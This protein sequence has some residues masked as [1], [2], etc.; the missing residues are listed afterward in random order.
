L[1]KTCIIIVGPTAVGKTSLAI[2]LA[3]HFNTQII[4]ADSRQ[5]FTALNIGVAKPS[6]QQLNAVPHHF[7]NSHSISD[8]INAAVFEQYALNKINNIFEKNDYAVMVGG[9]GLYV[10][11]FCNGIDELPVINATIRKNIIDEYEQH[12]LS[13]LQNKVQQIDALYFEK[14]EIKNP[15]RLMRALE[16]KLSTGQS[17]LSFQTQQKKNRDFNIL[18]IGLHLPKE[19]L[20][21][22]IN[23]RVD[24]MLEQGLLDEVKSL[25]G[26]KNQNALQTVGYTELFDYLEDKV[27]FNQAVELIKIHTRQYAKRQLTWFKK[28]AAIHWLSPQI[29]LKDLLST[30]A[31]N[32]AV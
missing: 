1:K 13:W 26:F 8:E 17:I 23:D 29:S 31:K 14:G 21:K 18:K 7:I 16:V 2:L 10:N 12:G 15:Q 32:S 27:T 11:S 5:C 24:D 3:Q 19:N 4:S 25:T 22:N 28:D 20:I 9:T 30:L 6:L